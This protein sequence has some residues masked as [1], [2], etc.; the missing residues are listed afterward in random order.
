MTEPEAA[1]IEIDGVPRQ[2]N[3]KWV[4]LAAVLVAAA[5]AYFLLRDFL[6]LAALA[7][8][9]EQLRAFAAT[10]PAVAIGTAFLVYVIVTGLS[11]PGAAVMTLVIGW[12]FG[13]ATGTV[14]VSFASTLGATLAFLFARF[15]L[16]ESLRKKF[17]ERLQNFERNF[18][19]DGPFY[20]FT[21]RLIAGVPFW[22]VN[23]LMGLTTIQTR[24]FWWVSQLGM[25]PGTMAYVYAGSTID[26]QA[27]ANDGLSGLVSGELLIAFT[28]LGLLPI[29]IKKL[30]ERFRRTK[31]ATG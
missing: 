12:M 15:L 9:E 20:L 10:S 26:L 29:T 8:R 14:L 1:P 23:L 30:V 2:R 27:A 24:T 21:L 3:V 25:L 17:S 28:I 18:E 4:V 13:F 19:K 22:M 5:T 7:A 6:S 31:D 11:L 16:R